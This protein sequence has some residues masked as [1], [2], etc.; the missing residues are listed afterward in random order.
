MQIINFLYAEKKILLPLIWLY[1]LG[2]IFQWVNLFTGN[3]Y[4]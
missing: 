3:I 2:A 4:L 1:I